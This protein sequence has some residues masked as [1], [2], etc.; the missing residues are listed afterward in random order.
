MRLYARPYAGQM[1]VM[2][3]TALLAVAAAISIPLVIRRIVDGP[4]THG[5]RSALL[6]LAA[7]ALVLGVVEASLNFT[8]RWIQG[9]STLGMER[10]IR[11][12][13]YRHLQSL[14]PAFH[15]RWLS[16]QLLSR[17][18]SDLS[19]VRRFFGFGL[20][21]LVAN[22]AT[23]AAI[24]TLLVR[25]D[26]FLGLVVTAS[27]VPIGFLCARFHHQFSGVSRRVQDQTGDLASRVEEAAQ[28]I[29][30]VKAF[31]RRRHIVD[32][33][34]ADSTEV[35][36][37]QLEKVRIR[38][39]FASVLDVI[40]NATLG[41]VLV[42]GALAVGSGRISLGDLVAFI[43][44]ALQLVWPVEALGFILASAQEAGT[45]AQRVFEVL[46]T[47]PE[48][49]SPAVPVPLTGP[50]GGPPVGRVR[51]EGVGYR[52]PG[53]DRD[54]LHDID[55]E[56]EPGET[57]ALVGTSGSGKTT[58]AMLLP[59]LADA[60]RGRVTIDGHDVRDVALPDL[61]TVVATAFEEPILFSASVRENVTLGRPDATD[62]DV[63]AALDL[64][65]ARFAHDLPWGLDTRVGEQGMSLSG[66]QRQ[67]LA[68]ARAVLGRPRVLVLDD[69][70]S[71]LDVETEALV[72]EALRRV[73]AATTAVV[74]V[75]RP[76]TVALADRVAF[77]RDGT[78]EAVGTHADL[79]ATNHAYAEVMGDPATVVVPG[80]SR[81]EEV[82]R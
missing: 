27:L 9:T 24:C 75:H 77:L 71:A 42:L 66:G 81:R 31:G 16:G 73:L 28:G 12:V 50:D 30:V 11:D 48:I 80:Q 39:G 6:P 10:D 26:V 35:R 38:A 68:L 61:R 19:A 45:A 17:L 7:L 40:P 70:L 18:T 14:P 1:L 13:L 69:P 25:I 21:F 47:E 52:F 46:D 58:L 37:T 51:F 36:G 59:R 67:R 49:A 43:T 72:E 64:A 23:F 79:M 15:D 78:V 57:L 63:E 55:L 20:I 62:A 5:D 2:L 3:A 54:V 34:T 22:V 56:L 8:R 41:V 33:Y 74:V 65:Q 4:V 53:S 32:Q 60:T 29:R 44:L 82:R 76:S